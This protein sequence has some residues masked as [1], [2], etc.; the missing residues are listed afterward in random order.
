LTTGID[1][2]C[3]TPTEMDQRLLHRRRFMK[4]VAGGSILAVSGRWNKLLGQMATTSRPARFIPGTRPTRSLVVEVNGPRLLQTSGLNRRVLREMIVTGMC[5][6]TGTAS[7]SSAL[8]KLFEPR[9]IIG[10]KF[11]SSGDHL[12]KTNQ[13]LAEELLRL[14]L[15]HNFKPEQLMF[16][17]VS[18][19]DESLP[20]PVKAQFGWTKPVDFGSGTDQLAATLE[21]VTAI[22]N[23]AS[24]RAD[25]I[26]GIAGCLRNVTYG[27][28]RHPGR[29]FGDGYTPYIAD[30]YN[31]PVIRNKLRVNLINAIRVIIRKDV[32]DLPDAIVD[33]AALLF[34]F[35]PVAVDAAGFEMIE[36]LR[37]EAKLGPL[38]KGRDAPKQL[39]T[40]S[41]KG[42]GNYY[43]DQRDL[44]VTKVQ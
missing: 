43:P 31:I 6:L 40:A 39:L 41:K 2:L 30:I 26:G 11:D 32:L 13:P 24:L 18:P 17:G 33:H 7:F 38:L 37:A 5:E 27:F 42:L 8:G 25:A 23:V 14:F 1:R 19:A 34:S 16:I 36:H 3:E 20:D 29:F 4:L 44:R 10:F 21:K 22:V 12:A 35:D 15:M 28:L 9:D